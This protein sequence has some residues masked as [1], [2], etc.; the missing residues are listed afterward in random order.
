MTKR[1]RITSAE[2][3]VLRKSGRRC[4]VCFG[5]YRHLGV[6]R[7]QIAHLDHNPANS[8]IDNLAFLCIEHHDQYDSRTSQSKGLT[9]HEV[10]SYRTELYQAMEAFRAIEDERLHITAMAKLEQ[11]IS[12]QRT[13]YAHITDKVDFLAAEWRQFQENIGGQIRSVLLKERD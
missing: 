7:G 10:K 13:W 8:T 3:E 1:R 9:L 4:C 12:D 6:K 11:F 5:L 2:T